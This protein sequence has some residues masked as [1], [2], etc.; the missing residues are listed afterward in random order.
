MTKTIKKICILSVGEKKQISIKGSF[1]SN[2]ELDCAVVDIDGN[3]QS[4]KIDGLGDGEIE[5]LANGIAKIIRNREIASVLK[6]ESPNK[7]M[8]RLLN[9]KSGRGVAF[10]VLFSELFRKDCY[11]IE[12]DHVAKE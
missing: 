7:T 1:Y 5:S 8:T 10:N 2:R 4:I 3:T 12:A 11:K 9:E 6:V